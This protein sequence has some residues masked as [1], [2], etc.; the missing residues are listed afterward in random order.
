MNL[1]FFPPQT[2]SPYAHFHSQLPGGDLPPLLSKTALEWRFG[3]VK[4]FVM[5]TSLSRPK[6]GFRKRHHAVQNGAGRLAAAENLQNAPEVRFLPLLKGFGLCHRHG[7]SVFSCPRRHARSLFWTGVA[8]C[9]PRRA[10]RGYER[11]GKYLL[12]P[13][14]ATSGLPSTTDGC[15]P[16]GAQRVISHARVPTAG[17]PWATRYRRYAACD[18]TDAVK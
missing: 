12:S 7:L 16:Y 3:R 8:S 11:P 13:A 14:G 17:S 18:N 5:N 6:P 4:S 2:R 9:G 10:S 15:R 1:R